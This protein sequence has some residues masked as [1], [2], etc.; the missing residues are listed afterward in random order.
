MRRTK[1]VVP[2]PIAEAL[3]PVDRASPA[4]RLHT[5]MCAPPSVPPVPR[6]PP[7]SS[8]RLRH[9]STAMSSI[10]LDPNPQRAS[11]RLNRD[12]FHNHTGSRHS[13]RFGVGSFRTQ[14]PSGCPNPGHSDNPQDCLPRALA[15]IRSKP[16]DR[17]VRGLVDQRSSVWPPSAGRPPPRTNRC[18]AGQRE[19]N[20]VRMHSSN[21]SAFQMSIRV[22]W[23]ARTMSLDS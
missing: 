10:Y 7:A 5:P 15:T 21:C 22:C 16:Q 18:K 19:S 8:T 14:P 2:M 3:V 23:P 12:P 6:H 9:Q 4:Q 11:R 1:L 20:R 17:A 13:W